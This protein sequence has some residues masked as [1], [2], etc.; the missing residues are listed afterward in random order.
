VRNPADDGR[1]GRRRPEQP[2]QNGEARHAQERR[3]P[4]I[5]RCPARWKR[6]DTSPRALARVPGPAGRPRRPA[7]HDRS[8]AAAES[9]RSSA[10]AEH[11]LRRRVAGPAP[12]LSRNPPQSPPQPRHRDV[13]SPR[14][15]D[16]ASPASARSG[17]RLGTVRPRRRTRPPPSAV[18]RGAPAYAPRTGETGRT[19]GATP[20]RRNT[21]SPDR[22]RH[23]PVAATDWAPSTPS[24]G[25]VPTIARRGPQRRAPAA[26]PTPASSATPA[27][28]RYSVRSAGPPPREQK[29]SPWQPR[30][31]GEEQADRRGAVPPPQR[32]RQRQ[33]GGQDHRPLRRPERSAARAAA[34]PAVVVGREVRTARPRSRS[35]TNTTGSIVLSRP[36]AEQEERRATPLERQPPPR[37]GARRTR[38]R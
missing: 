5:E 36:R 1:E 2:A 24:P 37:P 15:S 23:R 33:P 16:A 31:P 27:D 35:S 12:F 8:A 4:P 22:K 34:R 7:G 18:R 9:R 32:E 30:D 28:T 14:A 19:P 25:T 13:R 21:S 26:A 10:R 29:S 6:Q 3:P 38:P 11:A 20:A 17:T